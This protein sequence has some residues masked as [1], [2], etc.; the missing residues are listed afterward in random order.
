MLTT[1]ASNNRF[2]ATVSAL[3]AWADG[4][5]DRLTESVA[6]FCAEVPRLL[7]SLA[8]DVDARNAQAVSRT[9][10]SLYGKLAPFGVPHLRTVTATLED[11]AHARDLAP[12]AP[13]VDEL[14]AALT[15]FCA[16]LA[17]KPWTR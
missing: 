3:L 2:P 8:R 9:A 7:R 11:Y 10:H 12:A 1:C 16:Y 6:S 15:G 14:D 17:T 13:L 4:D 5:T